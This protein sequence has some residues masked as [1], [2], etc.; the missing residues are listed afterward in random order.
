MIYFHFIKRF[1]FNINQL[2][3]ASDSYKALLNVEARALIYQK[4]LLESDVKKL[5]ILKF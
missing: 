3:N 2:L 1:Q 4:I 5:N